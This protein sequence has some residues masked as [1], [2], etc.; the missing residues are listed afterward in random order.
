MTADKLARGRA[1][2]EAYLAAKRE[3]AHIFASRAQLRLTPSSADAAKRSKGGLRGHK[4][5]KM[6]RLKANGEEE[7]KEERI[8]VRKLVRELVRELCEGIT[9]LAIARR[10]PACVSHESLLAF[11]LVNT[12]PLYSTTREHATTLLNSC[13]HIPTHTPP[14]ARNLPSARKPVP[15]RGRPAKADGRCE[16]QLG[17]RE[18]SRTRTEEEQGA[19]TGGRQA[20]SPAVQP[21]AVSRE[22]PARPRLHDF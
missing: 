10:S 6:K 18:S 12:P 13:T 20:H 3:R 9:T 14:R 11:P 5:P 21:G 17:P 19:G 4:K 16:A 7:S 2:R 8:E 1:S 15:A 22:G